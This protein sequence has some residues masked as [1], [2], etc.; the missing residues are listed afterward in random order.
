M[1]KIRNARCQSAAKQEPKVTLLN[2]QQKILYNNTKGVVTIQIRIFFLIV[3]TAQKS[4][5]TFQQ[6]QVITYQYAPN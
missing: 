6:C 4:K 3:E 1:V 5:D 2:S